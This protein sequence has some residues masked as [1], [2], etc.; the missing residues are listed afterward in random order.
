[1]NY[2]TNEDITIFPFNDKYMK[3]DLDTRQ[4]ILQYDAV[5]DIYNIDLSG[6]GQPADIDVFLLECSDD[7][8]SH[9]YDHTSLDSVETKLY[10]IA[11]YEENRNI[12][13]RALLAQ[14]RYAKRSSANLLKDMH[15]VNIEK[16]K[17]VGI[18]NLRGEI[19]LAKQAHSLLSKSGL[20][21]V[22]SYG[23]PNLEGYE[24]GSY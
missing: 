18:N 10:I 4:Y 23:V 22:G 14:V 7:V 21:F 11:K 24:D 8:S 2:I 1:M 20:L 13:L 12:I 6:L 17:F 3:Y 16:A 15:G 9:I 5:K 19:G